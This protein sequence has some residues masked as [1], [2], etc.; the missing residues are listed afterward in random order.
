M[1]GGRE[2][3]LNEM[4][5]LNCGKE[6]LFLVN[7]DFIWSNISELK[8]SFEIFSYY[9][10]FL[11]WKRVWFL[12]WNSIFPYSMYKYGEI[13]ISNFV[14]ICGFC[15]V[16]VR[17]FMNLFRINQWLIIC[18]LHTNLSTEFVSQLHLPFFFMF[19][20]LKDFKF[21]EM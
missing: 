12:T 21:K 17:I 2:W 8:Q 5:Y 1:C 13:S 6:S 4:E 14:Y 18:D 19:R 11:P 3:G 20:S 15:Y 16:I 7:K 10:T 9:L